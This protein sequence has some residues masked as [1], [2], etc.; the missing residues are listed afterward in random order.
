[1]KTFKVSWTRTAER[2]LESLIDFIALENPRNALKI[3]RLIRSK[4]STLR[5]TPGRGRFLPEFRHMKGLPF[6]EVISSPWRLIY[7][8]HGAA[9]EVLSLLDGRRDLEDILFERLT[10]IPHNSCS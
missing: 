4:A 1:M 10:T 2:D 9:V 6:W 8:I 3:L 7:R 5:K